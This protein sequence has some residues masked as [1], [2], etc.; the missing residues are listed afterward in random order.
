MKRHFYISNDLD[1]LETLEADLHEKGI[2]HE[3][4]H[5][6]SDDDAELQKHHL[7]QV[8]SIFKKDVVHGSKLGFFV[9]LAAAVL[10]LWVANAIGVSEPLLWF[11]IVFL[12]VFLLGFCT[13]EGGLI[14]FQRPNHHFTKFHKVLKHGKHVVVIDV[15]PAQLETLKSVM[16][17]HPRVHFAG[18]GD[19]VPDWMVGLQE[20][21]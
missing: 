18:H 2:T 21:V 12:A 16:K 5:I 1:D 15:T 6:L 20:V 8:A 3:Q 4:V 19:D 7:H 10:L 11:P 17:R 9:G 14:G 13:W